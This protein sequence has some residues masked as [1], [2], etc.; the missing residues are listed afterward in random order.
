MLDEA[1]V[2]A[3]NSA[4]DLYDDDEDDSKLVPPPWVLQTRTRQVLMLGRRLLMVACLFVLHAC[5]AAAAS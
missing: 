5:V 4:N 1:F 3:H 2:V